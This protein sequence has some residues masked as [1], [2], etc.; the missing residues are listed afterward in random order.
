MMRWRWSKL[1][2]TNK[3]LNTDEGSD[4]NIHAIVISRRRVWFP[5]VESAWEAAHDLNGL[6]TCGERSITHLLY[7]PGPCRGWGPKPTWNSNTLMRILE[8]KVFMNETSLFKTRPPPSQRRTTWRKERR[9]AEW[10]KEWSISIW[11]WCSNSSGTA[12]PRTFLSAHIHLATTT[13]TMLFP[14]FNGYFIVP[15]IYDLGQVR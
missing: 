5:S 10:L 1:K 14:Y 7:L 2:Q 11:T 13:I 15:K 4:I 6:H 12:G 3:Q 8:L 9:S